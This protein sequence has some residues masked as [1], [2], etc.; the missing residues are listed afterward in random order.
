MKN[1]KRGG[2]VSDLISGVGALIIVVIVILIVVSTLLG[3]KLLGTAN[4][5]TAVT[6]EEH[7]WINETTYQLGTSN[8]SLFDYAIT[9]AINGTEGPVIA[10]GNWT[11]DTTAGTLVNASDDWTNVT[12]NYTYNYVGHSKYSSASEDMS[13]NFTTGINNVSEKIPTVLLIGAV[14]LLFGVIVLLIRQTDLI[15]FGAS[16][17]SL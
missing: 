5:N 17:G 9:G 6:N 16:N 14:V 4:F 1:Q 7:G 11:L 8:S 2:I 12:F 3:A 13:S 10:T 15:G